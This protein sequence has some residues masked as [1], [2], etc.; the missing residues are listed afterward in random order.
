MPL[1]CFAGGTNPRSSSNGAAVGLRQ[2]VEPF[3]LAAAHLQGP[4]S[5]MHAMD[6]LLP[7]VLQLVPRR[8]PER[9]HVSGS[10][11]LGATLG[12]RADGA[13]RPQVAQLRLD[14]GVD[15]LGEV[16]LAGRGRLLD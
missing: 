5:I 1:G 6:H 12:G 15:L 14:D 2:T 4:V 16:R 11:V 10:A 8:P 3:G 9:E 13:D 7:L